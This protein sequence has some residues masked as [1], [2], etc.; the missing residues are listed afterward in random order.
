MGGYLGHETL[1]G[2]ISS[3]VCDGVGINPLDNRLPHKNEYLQA[4]IND[5]NAKWEADTTK[6]P[7]V[8]AMYL[9]QVVL[10]YDQSQCSSL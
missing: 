2:H 3:G 1:D 4:H 5:M 8:F 6:V 10:P 7:P 9:S